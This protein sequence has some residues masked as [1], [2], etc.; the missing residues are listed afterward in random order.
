ME[1]PSQ[2]KCHICGEPAQDAYA[3]ARFS[4]RELLMGVIYRGV[5]HDCL[6]A[7]IENI[8]RDRH[9]RGELLVWPMVLLP[10]GALL[11]ALSKYVASQIVGYALLGLAVAIPILMRFWQ[12][13]EALRAKQ[14]SDE[15]N[16]RR[17]SERMC[18]EDAQLTSRQTK[19]IY[20]KPEYA[21]EGM[22]QRV[23]HET[24][25]HSETAAQIVKLS[26]AA[27]ENRHL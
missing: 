7:Y 14:A 17:Y 9:M 12:R 24:S 4:E 11:A 21:A 25:V 13:R 15:E 19:L 8:K 23:M 16:M 27:Q 2:I 5:C 1:H 3:Y 18:R 26:L 22:E 6:R 10:V 20:L